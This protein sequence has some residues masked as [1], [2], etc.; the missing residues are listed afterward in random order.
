MVDDGLQSWQSF[1]VVMFPRLLS[2]WRSGMTKL[3]VLLLASLLVMQYFVGSSVYH[4]RIF[5]TRILYKQEWV[6]LYGTRN[7]GKS[8]S[9]FYSNSTVP[10]YSVA[11]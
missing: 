10:K 4:I 7:D 11:A 3:V 8:S 1:I 2:C 6:P 5:D 9:D